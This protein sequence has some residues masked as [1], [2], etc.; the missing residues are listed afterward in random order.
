MLAH[1]KDQIPVQVL[2]AQELELLRAGA[3]ARVGR[4]RKEAKGV[5]LG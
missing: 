3:T 2:Q 5:N 4:R 1:Q